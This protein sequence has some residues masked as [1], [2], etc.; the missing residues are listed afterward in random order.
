MYDVGMKVAIDRSFFITST[1]LFISNII[2][3]TLFRVVT[4]QT[5]LIATG[6]P[7]L[8]I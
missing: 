4:F 6:V 1:F 3:P 8:R 5:E 7:L 2:M